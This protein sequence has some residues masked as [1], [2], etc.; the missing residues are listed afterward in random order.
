MTD[1]DLCDRWE[2]RQEQPLT[3]VPLSKSM[4]QVV[5]LHQESFQTNCPKDISALATSVSQKSSQIVHCQ[6]TARTEMPE[7][8]EW[9]L[10]LPLTTGGQWWQAAA[11]LDFFRSI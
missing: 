5:R 11:G 7:L 8:T 2:G 3:A 10:Q 9:L 1:T 4:V 6:P